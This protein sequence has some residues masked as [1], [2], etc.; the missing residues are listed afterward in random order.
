MSV[1][2]FFEK[3]GSELKKLFGSTATWE[4]TARSVITY[5]APILETIIGLAAGGP[6]EAAVSGVV[7]SIQADL[8]TISAVVQ[9]AA[10]TP[11]SPT[12]V[13]VK[14]A[15][16]SIK[17]NLG[18]LLADADIKNSTKVTEITAAVN[19]ISGEVEALLA[20]LPL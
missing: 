17:A 1:K 3:F 8:A 11:R 7:N 10:V 14:T 5:V 19:G 16:E 6:A 15:L 20:N 4:Q 18:S 13:T 2:T 12:A 9:G